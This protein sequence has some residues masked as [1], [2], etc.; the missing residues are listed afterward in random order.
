MWA[1]NNFGGLEG[2]KAQIGQTVLSILQSQKLFQGTKV[3]RA[4]GLK[5]RPVDSELLGLST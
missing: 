1:K 2:R 5:G 3:S 4:V